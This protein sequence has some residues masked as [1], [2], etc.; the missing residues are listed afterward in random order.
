MS[1]PPAENRPG[2]GPALIARDQRGLFGNAGLAFSGQAGAF[3]VGLVTMVVT[4]RLLG[5]DGYGRLGLF[6]MLLSVTSKL[7]VGWPNAG[8]VRF[9]REELGERNRLAETF[10]ARVVL[11][12]ASIAAAA[13]IL[14]A[15]RFRVADYLHIRYAPHV[16]LL[17]YVGLNEF[18]MATMGVFQTVGDFRSYA[19]ATFFARALK[20]PLILLAFFVLAI[21]VGVAEVITAHLVALG[22]VAVWSAA[23]LPWRKLTPFGLKPAAVARII[24]YSWPLMLGGLSMIVVGW[25]DFVVIKHFYSMTEVGW[26][27]V[28]Y[29]PLTVIELVTLA[30]LGVLLP[31]LVSLAVEKRHRTLVWYL[32]DA[33]PQIAWATGLA[34]TL[35]AGAAEAIPLVLGREFSPSVLP[36]QVLMA[37]VAFSVVGAAQMTVAK[38]VD[39]VGGLTWVLIALAA[40]NV[41]LDVLL[42]PRHGILGAATA[43]ALA[44]ATAG[45]LYFPLLNSTSHIRGNAPGRRYWATLVGLLPPVLFA[46]FAPKLPT[47]AW[48]LAAC[49]ALLAAALAAARLTGV[50]KASTLARLSE[51]RMPHM[52][53]KT[54]RAF[55]SAFG[56]QEDDLP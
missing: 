37:G 1:G 51:V 13:A 49:G 52:V 38:A 44:F 26:Y 10:W 23:A 19:T 5:P 43:T 45:I 18:I 39:R 21:H 17:L 24:G 22:I 12:L 33:L 31:L 42:V 41:V 25:V 55:Y 29:Q 50:F 8:L 14:T 6:I 3:A 32:D 54:L 15:L 20:L 27:A 53:G 4:A 30:L 35:A 9:G 47:P 46:V 7:L 11:F 56:R 40:L 2:F 34:C 48:R 16:L 36:C 28:A